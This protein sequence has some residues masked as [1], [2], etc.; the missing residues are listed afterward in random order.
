MDSELHQ[1]IQASL[2]DLRQEMLAQVR[3]MQS[4]W[5]DRQAAADYA[6]VT[7]QKIDQ[8]ARDGELTRYVGLGDARY[9]K[10]ELDGVIA[11]TQRPKN[12]ITQ[13]QDHPGPQRCEFHGHVYEHQPA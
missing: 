3:R 8:L 13:V 2:A 9:K 1:I 7:P 5:L 12:P 10:T 4:P 11:E 6:H